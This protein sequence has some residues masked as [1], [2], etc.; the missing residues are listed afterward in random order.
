M[1]PN[2]KKP[3]GHISLNYSVKD[4]PKLTDRKM[5][6]LAHEYMKEIGIVNT[7][8]IIV[9]HYDRE[10]FHVHIVFNLID[11]NGKTISDKNDCCRNEQVCKQLKQKYGLYFAP[12]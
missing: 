8:Y 9:R 3:V 12:D 10:H 11:N 6:D 5:T 4:A 7:Q 1:N 2:I